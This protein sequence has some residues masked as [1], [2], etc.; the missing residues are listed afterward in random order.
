[1]L[2]ILVASGVNIGLAGAAIVCYRAI[3]L[4]AQGAVGGLAFITLTADLRR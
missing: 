1:M 2:G 3:S 4:G